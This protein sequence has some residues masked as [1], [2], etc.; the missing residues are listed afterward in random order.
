MGAED[1]IDRFSERGYFGMLGPALFTRV[2]LRQM[3]SVGG[4]TVNVYPK[5]VAQPSKFSD[6]LYPCVLDSVCEHCP[7]TVAQIAAERDVEVPCTAGASE[8]AARRVLE[9]LDGA[10]S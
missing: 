4:A 8:N 9:V 6:S 5:H 1:W 10:S 2:F 7:V 3:F